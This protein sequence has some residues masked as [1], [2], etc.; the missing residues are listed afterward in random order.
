M[1]CSEGRQNEYAI[2]LRGCPGRRAVHLFVHIRDGLLSLPV[3]VQDLEEC[4]VHA[5]VRCKARL[6]GGIGQ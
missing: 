2:K 5:F 1:Q 6:Q 4:F 3:H